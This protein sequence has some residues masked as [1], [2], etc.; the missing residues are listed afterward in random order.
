MGEQWTYKEFQINDG[1]KP[2]AK[3]FQYFFVVSEK[4][5]KKCKYCVW[6]EDEALTNFDQSKDFDSIISANREDWT[7]WVKSKID[8]GGSQATVL[9]FGKEGQQEI[10]LAVMEQHFSM[11]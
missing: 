5:E 7:K 8:E 11:D 6:I 10:D 3:H 4:G 2:E 1:L 9:K